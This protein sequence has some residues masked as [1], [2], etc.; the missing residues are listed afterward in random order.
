MRENILKR[1]FLYPTHFQ[2]VNIVDPGINILGK[3]NQVTQQG[4]FIKL[5]PTTEGCFPKNQN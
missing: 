5:S 3:F 1:V 4:S 2:Y